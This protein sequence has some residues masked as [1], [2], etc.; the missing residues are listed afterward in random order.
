MDSKETLLNDMLM[1]IYRLTECGGCQADEN[2][3][4][5]PCNKV[6]LPTPCYEA[7]EFR[8][9]NLGLIERGA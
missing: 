9:K 8:A 2:P 1:C 6:G 3:S 4:V 5:S 7:F